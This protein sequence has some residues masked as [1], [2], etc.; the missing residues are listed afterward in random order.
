MM[1]KKTHEDVLEVIR[2]RKE[3]SVSTFLHIAIIHLSFHKT[4]VETL[5]RDSLILKLVMCVSVFPIRL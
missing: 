1:S 3:S 5:I 4:V 2:T